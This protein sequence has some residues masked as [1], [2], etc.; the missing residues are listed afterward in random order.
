M[1]YLSRLNRRSSIAAA[2]IILLAL[3]FNFAHVDT[4]YFV[5]VTPTGI[6]IC[7]VCNKSGA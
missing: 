4:D 1:A 7:H 3:S 5:P 2:L 6:L